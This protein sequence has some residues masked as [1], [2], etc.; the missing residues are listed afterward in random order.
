MTSQPIAPGGAG[1]RDTGN[2]TDPFRAVIR[3][4]FVVRT[5]ELGRGDVIGSHYVQVLAIA[6]DGLRSDEEQLV[7]GGHKAPRNLTLGFSIGAV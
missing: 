1:G 7:G 6:V 2:R 5:P 4:E 3:V